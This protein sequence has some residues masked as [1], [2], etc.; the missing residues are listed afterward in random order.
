[1]SAIAIVELSSFSKKAAKILDKE[2]LD[3]LHAYLLQHPDK[4]DVIPSTGGVRKL[5]WAASG[6]G[7]RG[8]ARVI[9]F[10]H[11][12]GTTIYLM[13]CY[14]KNEQDNIRPEVKKQM[15]NFVTHIKKGE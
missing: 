14:T 6:R 7:K 4:G 13:A 1:M 3:A 9:Y 11:V 10:Y 5:R 12:V 2:E 15:T 8:G